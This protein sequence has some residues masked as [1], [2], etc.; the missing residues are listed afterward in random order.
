MSEVVDIS[1]KFIDI[2]LPRHFGY[3]KSETMT[4]G[5]Y[6]TLLYGNNISDRK[7][8]TWWEIMF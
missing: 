6:N 5:F 3:L 4:I 2:K 7:T 1:E 8:F